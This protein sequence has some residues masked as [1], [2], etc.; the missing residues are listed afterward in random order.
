MKFIALDSKL[1]ECKIKTFIQLTDLETGESEIFKKGP[2]AELVFT[3]SA[4]TIVTK[5]YL[6]DVECCIDGDVSSGFA[7]EFLKQQGADVVIGL[8]CNKDD[9]Y[10][11]SNNH[12]SIINRALDSFQI[13]GKTIRS[14]DQKLDPVAL[15]HPT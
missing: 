5:P 1:E 11:L 2:I 13:A 6:Y 4:M 14:L 8:S 10:V 9:Q 7:V 3:S 15:L 12:T